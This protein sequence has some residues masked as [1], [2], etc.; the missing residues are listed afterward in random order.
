MLITVKEAAQLLGIQIAAV[1]FAIRK[2]R[3]HRIMDVNGY[4][5]KLDYDEVAKYADS[6]YS[7]SESRFNGSLLFDKERG[8]YS[9]KEC[10]KILCVTKQ[11][12]YLIIRQGRIKTERKGFQLVITLEAIRAYKEKYQ[13]SIKVVEKVG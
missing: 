11:R 13:P 6:R 8:F 12:L 10:A 5:V 4:N 1:Q 9:V 3:L 7:R 2:G